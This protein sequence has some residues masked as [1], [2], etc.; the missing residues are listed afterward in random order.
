MGRGFKQKKKKKK[1]REV[2]F[3]NTILF[4]FDAIDQPE[5]SKSAPSRRN[6]IWVILF[7][8]YFLFSMQEVF[9][10]DDAGSFG[11]VSSDIRFFDP[12]AREGVDAHLGITSST[13]RSSR[14][15]EAAGAAEND[16][17]RVAMSAVLKGQRCDKV[18]CV[19][20]TL[21]K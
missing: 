4:P 21:K 13:S 9:E 1:L 11:V 14:A 17:G 5:T 10:D 12:G 15:A 8:I 18:C 16:S 6:E 3:F 7:F 20:M 19:P 2:T